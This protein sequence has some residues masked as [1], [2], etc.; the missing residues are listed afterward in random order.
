MYN[1]IN[2]LILFG[3]M[4]LQIKVIIQLSTFWQL[5]LGQLG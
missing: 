4:Y 1:I 5:V 3:D 2:K